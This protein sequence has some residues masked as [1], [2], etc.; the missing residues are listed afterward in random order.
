MT[1]LPV[2]YDANGVSGRLH[3]VS[4]SI[5]ETL[6][7]LSNATMQVRKDEI[8]P[9]RTYVELFTVNGSAGI[10]RTRVPQAVYGTEDASI[11]LDHAVCEIGDYMVTDKIEAE[12]TVA[13]AFSTLFA[14]YRGSR[15]QLGT[16]T[17]SETVTVDCDYDNLLEVLLGILEQVPQYRMVFNFS[18]TPWTVGIAAK[19]Q[20]VS[21]QGRLSRNI[22]SAT[23]KRDDKDLCTRVYVKGLPKPVGREDDDDAEGYMD[24]DTI[25]TYGVVEA[26][27]G[28]GDYTAEQAQRVAAA[29]LAAH[30]NPKLSVDIDADDLSMITGETL[31][32]FAVG[33]KFR[34]AVPDDGIV[35]EDY[36]TQISWGDVYGSPYQA[37]LTIGDEADAA[38][39]FLKSQQSKSKTAKKNQKKQQKKNANFAKQ[40][41][42]VDEHGNILQQAGMYLDE[43]GMITYAKDFEYNIGSIIDQTASQIRQEV[44]TLDS[45][46]RSEILQTA[47]Y[48]RSVVDNYTSDIHSEILQTSSQIYS[49]VYA[50]NSAVYSYIDQT[51]SGIRQEVGNAASGI[52]SAIEQTASGIYSTVYAS[53]S[54]VY[55]FI[56]QTASGIRQEVG[57]VESD[58]RSSI[59]QQAD[60]ISLVVETTDSGSWIKAAEI[61]TEINKS[62]ST[63]RINA[64]RV[65]VGSSGSN[66]TLGDVMTLGSGGA[67]I[68]NRE[69]SVQDISV[70][71]GKGITFMPGTGGTAMELKSSTIVGLVKNLKLEQNG[72]T[73]TLYKKS[74]AGSDDPDA[75]WAEVGSFSRAT[76]L[77]GGWNS[78]NFP[79]TVTASPQ[80]NTYSIGFTNASDVYLTVEKNGDPTAFGQSRKLI[81][82]PFKVVHH[83]GGTVG[84]QDRYTS[85]LA[86]VDASTVYGNGWEDSYDEVKLNY[87]SDQTV[88]PG[89]SVTVHAMAKPTPTGQLGSVTSITVSGAEDANLVAGNI[90]NNVTIFGVTGTYSGSGT[91]PVLEGDWSGGVY[92]V[93]SDPAPVA[94]SVTTLRA[95]TPVGNVSKN[96][97]SVSRTYKV[98]HG[99]DDDHLLDTGFSATV[100]INASEVYNDGWGD[101][102]DVVKL[103]Y[104]SDQTIDPGGSRTIHAMAKATPTSEFASVAS[105]TVSA[106]TANVSAGNWTA[107]GISDSGRASRIYNPSAGNGSSYTQ[108][109]ALGLYNYNSSGYAE[110]AING[111]DS[112]TGGTRTAALTRI[113]QMVAGGWNGNSNVVTLQFGMTGNM[114]NASTLTID[115][116]A[117]YNAGWGA[118][119]NKCSVPSSTS[120]GGS[121]TVTIP[122]ATVDG[123]AVEYSYAPS[124]DDT[125]AYIKQGTTTVARVTH[126][127]YSNGW[128]AARGKCSVP[129]SSSTSGSMTVKIPPATVDGAAAEYTYAPS[130]DNTY[131]YIK[132][133]TTTVARVTHSAYSNGWGAARGKCSVPTSTSTDGSMTVKIPPATVDGNAAEYSYSPSVDNSYAYIK[134]GT[135]TVA[136]VSHTVYSDGVATGR[137]QVKYIMPF[138]GERY[139]DN[140]SFN[141]YSGSGGTYYH[142]IAATSTQGVQIKLSENGANATSSNLTEIPAGGIT[143][144][145]N[146][147]F[148]ENS[149]YIGIRYLKVDVSGGTAARTCTYVE[150]GRFTSSSDPNSVL[151]GWNPVSVSGANIAA[152][153]QGYY[154]YIKFKVDGY[155]RSFYFA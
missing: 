72:N 85:S 126:S 105:V 18:T 70:A 151:S 120:T 115:G 14:Y 95:L 21:A 36:I 94:D 127:A 122:P 48:I 51:A 102:R 61:T 132:Q 117:R 75:D 53:E 45:A 43:H 40:F 38:L 123:A 143:A 25:G 71:S 129:T 103:N 150:G 138:A 12:K 67:I 89:G 155:Q 57:N 136:R 86:S 119:R 110:I 15:W 108:Y 92:T 84:D 96:G 26:E 55:S 9:V 91:T 137:G 124:A 139:G 11:Q 135:T 133:G 152:S 88:Q 146:Y 27:A 82:V 118:A 134:Q 130:A 109:L 46:L 60:R 6:K 41:Q 35:I 56:D 98:Q 54:S 44:T 76:A 114:V 58:L 154:R 5:R 142:K 106:N 22:R 42:K 47:T 69:M 79:L 50:N 148:M 29:Y 52:Y 121:M 3:P 39:S 49:A 131:A 17:A 68:F 28:S 100:T 34:L 125:Y 111:Y 93:T 153:A 81:N 13:Q 144:N 141:A 104:S 7:P 112:A 10:Y 64:N 66:I 2:V 4:L 20:N 128:G 37:T 24:A 8:L 1:K 31:D 32:R 19:E 78:G 77:S 30:K 59:T 101:S 33:K 99:V 107:K 147:K 87:V 63:A 62:G 149:G 16:I 83:A 23:V 65:V 90:K 73:Y 140:Y 113:S 74:F 80:G 97:T 145:G 116:S